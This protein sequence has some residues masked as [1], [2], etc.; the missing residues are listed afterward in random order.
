[1]ENRRAESNKIFREHRLEEVKVDQMQLL[2]LSTKM[3]SHQ[4]HDIS[5]DGCL[6]G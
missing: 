3:I 2:R 4:V 6:Q 1:M 5:H